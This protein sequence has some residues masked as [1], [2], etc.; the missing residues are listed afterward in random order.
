M[1]RRR[2]TLS[3]NFLHDNRAVHL[4]VRSSGAGPGDL[5]V[6]PGAGEGALTVALARVC[7]RV[8]A[9][10]IDPRPAGRLARRF[11]GHDGVRVIRGDFL[12][13]V[14]PGEPFAVVGNIPYSRTTDIVRWCLAAPTLTSATLLVQREYARKHTGDYGRWPR[15][16][17]LTWP[18]YEWRLG[19]RVARTSFVPVPRTDSAVLRLVR[20]P[21]P[22][23]PVER[24]PV[25][26]EFVTY[27]FTGTGGSLAATLTRRY[28][29]RAV[30][31]ACRAAGLD[32][33]VP[34]GPVPP[35]RW[36]ALFWELHG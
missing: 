13:A 14:P 23:L 15:L 10:E 33:A 19:A 3:Q 24:L 22:L 16:T 6:E 32:R 29:G 4:V 2:I 25:W 12:R 21:A 35:G 11:A 5:V 31:A 30:R 26:R 27:G 20:R 7:H 28:G 9:Y 18:G 8:V 34:V 1:A 36:L 17:V